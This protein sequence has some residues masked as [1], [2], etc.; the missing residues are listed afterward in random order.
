MKYIMFHKNAHNLDHYIPIIFPDDLTHLI[1]ATI[2]QCS[3]ELEGFK[4]RSAGSVQL[5]GTIMGRHFKT[6]CDGWSETLNLHSHADDARI[7]TL[8]EYGGKFG[9]FVPALDA[10]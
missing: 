4:V 8:Y 2:M 6:I 5:G 1:V 10:G 7:I 3:P 9:Q